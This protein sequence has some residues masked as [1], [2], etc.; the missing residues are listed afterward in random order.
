MIFNLI[1]L[2][3]NVSVIVL[4]SYYSNFN[5]LTSVKLYKYDDIIHFSMYFSV[6][7]IA[8]KTY[9]ESS[10]IIS[11]SVLFLALILPVATE[12]S[13]HYIPRR[14]PDLIDLYSNYFGLGVAIV[15]FLFYKYVKK[16]N[17]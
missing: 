8:I 15:V 14:T 7:L 16:N 13:Q 6:G 12:Y 10:G 4:L 11:F 17:N 2:L 3:I 5:D 9:F 1:I